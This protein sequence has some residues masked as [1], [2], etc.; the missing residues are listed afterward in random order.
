MPGMSLSI[1]VSMTV[2]PTAASTSDAV[3]SGW[4]YVTLGMVA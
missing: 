2:A 4:I 3:P 1:A